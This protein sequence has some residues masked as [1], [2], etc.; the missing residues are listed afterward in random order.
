MDNDK[1][2]PEQEAPVKNTDNAFV[3]VG[4]DGSPEIPSPSDKTD[5]EK[6]ENV[7]TVDKR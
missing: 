5:I 4:E 6:D 1:T 3:R 2:F 7:T